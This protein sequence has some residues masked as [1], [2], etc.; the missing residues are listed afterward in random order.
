MPAL[1]ASVTRITVK[2]IERIASARRDG[3]PHSA[4]SGHCGREHGL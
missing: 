1:E 2:I 4:R 3:L